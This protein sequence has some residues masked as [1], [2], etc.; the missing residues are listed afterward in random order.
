MRVW[1]V[2][3]QKGGVG[4]TTTVVSLGGL[5]ASKGNRVLLLD[6]DPHGSLTA[7]FRFDMD[8]LALSAFDLFRS[9]P[10][11]TVDRLRA[12]ILK[13]SVSNL[14][15]MPAATALA[16]T[17]RQLVGQEGMGLRVSRGLALLW[18]EY[19]YVIIDT[20]PVLGVLMINALAACERLVLPVQTEFLAL[21]GLERM[22]GTIRMVHRSLKRDF[23]HLIVPTLFDRRTQASVATLRTL[24]QTYGDELW[25]SFIPVDT[26]LRDASKEGRPSCEY[27]PETRAARAYVHLL[28]YL[29]HNDDKQSGQGA[30]R[31]Q[32]VV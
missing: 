21:K 14:D 6:L 3:N 18:D 28:D 31:T 26:R 17:E 27:D 11:P 8:T 10:K 2:A 16:T 13:T 23:P 19:D 15:L 29:L 25:N 5:L 32:A 30:V 4:K 1:A 7:Y 9:E 12:A 20:P 22:L 24:R